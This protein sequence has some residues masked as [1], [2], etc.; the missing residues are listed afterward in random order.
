MGEMDTSVSSC[1]STMKLIFLLLGFLLVQNV[2]SQVRRVVRNKSAG[3]HGDRRMVKRMKKVQKKIKITQED[4]QDVDNTV[5]SQR[6][7]NP[8]SLF[9]V[10]KFPNTECT[11]S[12]GNFSYFFLARILVKDC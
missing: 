11:T 7:L 8:F 4:N 12:Q 1:M 2:V 9:N 5:A 6:F 3:K 10:I